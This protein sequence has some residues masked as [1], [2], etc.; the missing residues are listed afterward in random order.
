MKPFNPILGE[1]FQ[2]IYS[3]GTVIFS[4]QVKKKKEKKRKKKRNK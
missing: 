4:E 2:G 3:D 1:T